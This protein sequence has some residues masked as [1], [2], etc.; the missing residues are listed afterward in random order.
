MIT[1]THLILISDHN[2]ILM[3]QNLIIMVHHCYHH[4]V[5][6]FSTEMISLTHHHHLWFCLITFTSISSNHHDICQHPFKNSPSS[7]ALHFL[8]IVCFLQQDHDVSTLSMCNPT[9]AILSSPKKTFYIWFIFQ[10]QPECPPL[11]PS[12]SQLCVA[13]SGTEDCHYPTDHC[14]CGHC[15]ENFT[16]TCA[17]DSTT[18]L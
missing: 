16:F 6:R 5:Y 13:P 9:R 8:I 18:A 2:L 4:I 17:P 1:V 12:P 7:P 10:I 3:I 11:P 14:C 15:P